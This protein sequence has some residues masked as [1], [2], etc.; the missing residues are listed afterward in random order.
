MDPV[1][2]N[3]LLTVIT[4]MVPWRMRKQGQRESRRAPSLDHNPVKGSGGIETRWFAAETRLPHIQGGLLPG[5]DGKTHPLLQVFLQSQRQGK[6]A[7]LSHIDTLPP[8][9]HIFELHPCLISQTMKPSLPPSFPSPGGKQPC[10]P[11][12]ATWDRLLPPW[13][14]AAF[15]QEWCDTR[16]IENMK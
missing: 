4:A 10:T 6:V 5:L 3:L 13:T 8:R 11:Q 15:L 2:S 7:C 1:S 16:L 14:S 12:K 9:G